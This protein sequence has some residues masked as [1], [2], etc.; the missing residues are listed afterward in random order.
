MEFKAV[1]DSQIFTDSDTDSDPETHNV[2]V[3]STLIIGKAGIG[4]STYLLENY[5]DEDYL[6]TA[7]TGIAAARIEAKTISSLFA[8]GPEC[9]RSVSLSTNIMYRQKTHLI[10][11]EKKGIVID[12]YYT[13]PKE[14]MDRVDEILQIMRNCPLPF[15]GMHL[16]LIGD[17]RQTASIGE[18]FVGSPL[19]K[20]LT[21]TKIVLPYHDK[22]RL[23]KRYM[24]FCNKFRNPKITAKEMI[25]LLKD[26]RFAKEE[27]PGYTVYHQNKYVDQ[28]NE[29]EMAKMTTDVIGTFYKTEY[30]KGC[31]IM[32]TNNGP[33]VYNGMLGKLQGFDAKTKELEIEFEDYILETPIKGV[34]FVP[35]HALTIHKA[36]CNSFPGINLYIDS[37]KLK[38]NRRDSI[39]LIY[40]ALTRVRTFKKCYIGWL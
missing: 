24:K 26:E 27:V 8:L 2:P 21:F 31:P 18:S 38:R 20:T 33:E 32:I 3:K 29:D 36:Q 11:R 40:T 7:F 6:R 28:R 13:L 1:D 5:P 35:A 4:K 23:K 34:K 37:S 22:M 12:E 14:V 25:E 9:D 15:G 17:N 19:Y 39:R 10:L 16:V 30:K